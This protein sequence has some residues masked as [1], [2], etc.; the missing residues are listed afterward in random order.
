[1]QLPL[2]HGLLRRRC[3]TRR[4]LHK[5][6]AKSRDEHYAWVF[7]GPSEDDLIGE[8]GFG[9]GASGDEVD[10]WDPEHG[11]PEDAV[12]L[13]SSVGHPDEF[14]LFPEDFGFQQNNQHYRHRHRH[15]SK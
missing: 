9:G 13:R 5:R 14:V 3:R 1:M 7:E 12:V 2:C 15:D 8:N 4:C 6:N 10:R 11:S